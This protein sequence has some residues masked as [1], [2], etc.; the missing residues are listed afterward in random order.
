[1]STLI[2]KR[3]AKALFEFAGEKGK[4]KEIYEELRSIQELYDASTE[5]QQF[6]SSPVIPAAQKAGLLNEMFHS[7]LKPLTLRFLFFLN[8]K[9][10]LVLLPPICAAFEELY[11]AANN[12]LPATIRCKFL[13]SKPQV[14]SICEKFKKSEKKDIE[15]QQT[16]DQKM[17]GGF[18]VKINDM[19]YD[20]SIESKLNKFKRSILTH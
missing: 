7:R 3:Y 17:L 19:V 14:D 18:T 1:M 5:F 2:A 15:P 16:I 11:L 6:L 20:H 8:H 13:L 10:R 4:V 9:A 12:I